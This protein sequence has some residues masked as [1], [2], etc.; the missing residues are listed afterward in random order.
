[1][2]PFDLEAALAG[3]PVVLSNG[4]KAYVLHR[5]HRTSSASIEL[6]GYSIGM[7]D[8][9]TQ[10]AWDIAGSSEYGCDWDIV[11]MW[12]DPP[13]TVKI[14]NFE[15]PKPESEPLERGTH[16]YL[17]D[18]VF[19]NTPEEC[20]WVGDLL[21]ETYLNNGYVHKTKEAAIQHAKVIIAINQG[22]TSLDE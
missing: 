7:N 20:K 5:L 8:D 6:I 3:E 11:G 2:K 18:I 10:E 16:Y 12:E 13:Q 1:M 4:L 17:T 21:D 22:K 14:G 9:Q 15:F 19:P